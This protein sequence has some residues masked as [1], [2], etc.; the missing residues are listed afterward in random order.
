MFRVFRKYM[1]MDEN[2]SKYRNKNERKN[3]FISIFHANFG[4]IVYL[5]Y[6][7]QSSISYGI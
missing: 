5:N 7:S 2:A 4:S 1:F 3:Y 6:Y